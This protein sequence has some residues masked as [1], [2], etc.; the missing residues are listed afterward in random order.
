[1]L[2]QEKHLISQKRQ[3]LKNIKEIPCERATSDDHF[4][5]KLS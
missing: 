2:K 1:M 4:D 3:I 5:C